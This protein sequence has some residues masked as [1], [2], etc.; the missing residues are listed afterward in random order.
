MRFLDQAKIYVQGGDGGNG[1]ISFRREKYIPRGGPNG[2]DGGHGGHVVARVDPELN[3]LIDYRYRQHFRAGRGAHGMGKDRTGADGAD[4]E[5]ALPLGTQILAEDGATLIADLAR[6]GAARRS[7]RAAAP[8]ASATAASSRRPTAPRARPRPGEPGEE[9]WLW[10][11]L[12]LL[13][14]AGL[15]GLPNAG[16]STFLAA[17]S[18]ARPKIADYPFT[19]LEPKLGTVMIDHDS[20]VIADIPGL[21]EGAHEGAGLG[22]RF[23]G[24]IERCRVLIHLVDATAAD[25]AAAY[26]TVRREL[27]EY[28]PELAGRPELVCLNKVDALGEAE[29][30]AKA[31]APARRGG[32]C[33]VPDLGRGAPRARRGAARGL[34]RDPRRP[35][36]G[37]GM[38]A[39]RLV[40]KIGSSLLVDGAGRLRRDWLDSLA[41]DLAACRQAGQ[42]VIVVT[43]GAIALGRAAL[44]LKARVLRL[45]DKQAAAAVGQINL[46][47]AYQASLAQHGLAAAQL[48][49]TLGDTESRRRYLNARSTI[50]ALLKLGVVPVVNENDTVATTEIRFGDND[51]LSARVA[52]MASAEELILLSDVDGLYTADPSRDPEAVRVGLVTEITPEIEAMAGGAGSLA[53]T[54][55]MASKLVAAKIATHAGCSVIIAPG[56]ASRPLAR[57]ADGGPCTRF[58]ARANPRRAR[59]EWIAGALAA[60]GVLRIDLGAARALAPRQQPAAG[61][62]D[63]DRRLVPAR[64]CGDRARSR[65]P[66]H[67][68]G[69]VRL[70]RRRRA[71]DLRPQDRGDRGAARLP[72]PRRADPSRRPGPALRRAGRRAGPAGAR[73]SAPC[74]YR[75]PWA[76]TGLGRQGRLGVECARN[77][78][79]KALSWRR[80]C[81]TTSKPR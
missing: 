59:K 10:L 58:P 33:G 48:L 63:R 15:L 66:G 11:R 9:R 64:R 2:G 40:V 53:G 26:A 34:R 24:H 61:R 36:G 32:A 77:R 21:I 56:S 75:A 35:R 19:T 13:A 22:D 37:A 4:V 47:H 70:R 69:A 79:G 52:V 80:H 38:S 60:M 31:D 49:L 6:P 30:E 45:E 29:I 51:R 54:G 78:V 74:Q 68:Q 1:C 23:L 71:P 20:F 67:R 73:A 43:S 72:R 57:L 44:A 12:K 17:V 25:V 65:R 3:T 46:A 76:S 81:A 8:A 62:G 5:L 55:G 18:R 16:K 28:G 7:W 27:A 39:R 14:D 41:A 42:E 50:E